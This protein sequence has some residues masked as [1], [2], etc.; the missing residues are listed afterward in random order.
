[1]TMADGENS[2]KID[3]LKDARF[4]RDRQ[5][6]FLTVAYNSTKSFPKNM[7][8]LRYESVTNSAN[9][10]SESSLSQSIQSLPSISNFLSETN[11]LQDSKDDIKCTYVLYVVFRA[12]H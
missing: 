6:T 9:Y 3:Q 8:T 11:G 7:K 5:S 2:W 1:M 10:S 12:I 4:Q